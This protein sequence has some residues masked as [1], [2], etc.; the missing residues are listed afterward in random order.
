MPNCLLSKKVCC[1]SGV[2]HFYVTSNA[3]AFVAVRMK[4]IRPDKKEQK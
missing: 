2:V 3:F 4:N 1:V